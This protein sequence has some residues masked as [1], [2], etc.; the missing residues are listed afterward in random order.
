MVQQ[1]GHSE[2]KAT[3]KSPKK[4]KTP[5]R[6]DKGKIIAVQAPYSSKDKSLIKDTPRWLRKEVKIRHKR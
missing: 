1:E 5:K 6:S 3:E 2:E 4:E